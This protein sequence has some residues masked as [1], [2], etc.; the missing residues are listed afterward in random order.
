MNFNRCTLSAIASPDWYIYIYIYFFIISNINYKKIELRQYIY[1]M[2]GFDN[3]PL[4][5]VERFFF[6]FFSSYN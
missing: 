2:G 5:S 6:F 4:N 1:V 3:G